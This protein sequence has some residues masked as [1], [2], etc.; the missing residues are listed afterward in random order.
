ML[1]SQH[2]N[3][4]DTFSLCFRFL[5]STIVQSTSRFH[6]RLV[7]HLWFQLFL[8]LIPKAFNTVFLKMIGS[9]MLFDRTLLFVTNLTNN[10]FLEPLLSIRKRQKT[11]KKFWNVIY[12]NWKKKKKTY[13]K[14]HYEVWLI[15]IEID[16][17]CWLFNLN[18]YIM[19]E[20]YWTKY[21]SGKF[22]MVCLKSFRN[23]AF[24]IWMLS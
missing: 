1:R 16:F 12:L 4:F 9:V 21:F 8:I 22:S 13:Q 11:R 2:W 24:K 17:C 3:E 15:E 20:G 10:A 6:F 19:L 5:R 7:W 14:Y 18:I 23:K